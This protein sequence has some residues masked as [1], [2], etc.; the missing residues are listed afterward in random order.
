MGLK[1]FVTRELFPFTAG[2]IGRVVANILLTASVEERKFL[3]ILYVG[4]NVEEAAFAQA[5]PD[6]L[7]M[8]WPH[9]RYRGV[10]PDGNWFPPQAAFNHSFM[11]WES[12]H[13]LQ[14]LDEFERRH[15]SPEYVEFIDWGA[16]AFAPTQRKLSGVSLRSTTLAVRLHTTDSI[17]SDFEPRPQDVARL[18][19]FDIERKAL[20]DCDLIIGQLPPVAEAFR[21]FY[22]FSQAA[23]APRLRQHA[24]PVL[25]DTMPLASKTHRFTCETPLLFTSKLQD[26]K[27][28]DVFIRGCVQFMR[29]CPDYR[30]DVVFL[31]HSFDQAY[32]DYIDGL[33]PHDLKK[34]VVFARGVQGAAREKRIAE[35]VCIFPSP[36]ES[37]CLAAYEAGISG[38]V[39]VLNEQNPAFGEGVPWID[40]V[41]CGK[42]DGTSESLCASLLKLFHPD[43]LSLSPVKLREDVYPWLGITLTPPL[44]A[45]SE[46]TA[47]LSVVIVN[48]DGG[49]G[50]LRTLDS[51]LAGG[52]IVDQII[53]VDDASTDPRDTR[54]LDDLPQDDRLIIHRLEVSTGFAAARNIGLASVTNP[55]TAF[56]RSGDRLA[57]SALRLAAKAL[58]RESD[59][60]I[61]CGNAVLSDDVDLPPADLAGLHEVELHPSLHHIYYGEAQLSGLFENRFAPDTFVI[62]T[63]VARKHLFDSTMPELEVWEMMMRACQAGVRFIAV[64]EIM[65]TSSQINASLVGRAAGD[66]HLQAARR[67]LQGKRARLGKLDVPAYFAINHGGSPL[68]NG[69]AGETAAKLQELMDSETVR[70]TLALAHLM[71]RRA[72]WLLR[73]GKWLARKLHPVYQRIR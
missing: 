35:S 71:Q 25:L 62:R 2:G 66:L 15:G 68:V 6:V 18:A 34:R 61:Y 72:P 67:R 31:A 53:I 17:L 48:R 55:L 26:I 65:S 46:P 41:N 36:W 50:L 16:A 30:G 3:A 23:W 1:V 52:A 22:G 40:G 4:D 28:P 49:T 42:F 13:V 12:V 29:A 9:H 24:P 38:A 14:G 7:F 60:D 33:V 73:G 5:F 47:A 54:T 58:D 63:A 19:L 51:V 69:D 32:Q 21:K 10:D 20:A 43:A 59:F 56:V 11:H 44:D 45:L 64:A 27:R 57:P 70:Y 37:F 8:A 39:C